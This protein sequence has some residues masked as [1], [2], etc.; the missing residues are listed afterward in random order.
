[1]SQEGKVKFHC[2]S[3]HMRRHGW[4]SQK[5][6]QDERNK[7]RAF[8]W[9]VKQTERDHERTGKYCG[10]HTEEAALKTNTFFNE[11]LGS[12]S[13]TFISCYTIHW[14]HLEWNF[15]KDNDPISRL[16]TEWCTGKTHLNSIAK[17][18]KKELAFNPHVTEGWSNTVT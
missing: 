7:S 1:M 16:I 9:L 4:N 3:H 18:L 5:E 17:S 12:H 15:I 14:R 13:D 2:S 10:D 6:L 11:S 8:F